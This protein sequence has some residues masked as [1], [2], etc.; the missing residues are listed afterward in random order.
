MKMLQVAA[1]DT[2]ESNFHSAYD[3]SMMQRQ[4]QN[5]FKH[6]YLA[7]VILKPPMVPKKSF[8]KSFFPSK[9]Y[10]YLTCFSLKPERK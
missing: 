8:P 2:K 6:F 10:T 3:L 1:V 5:T 9:F 7:T 4:V